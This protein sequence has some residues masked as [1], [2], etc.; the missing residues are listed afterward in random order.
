LES[1]KEGKEKQAMMRIKSE[2]VRHLVETV[3]D[4]DLMKRV[5]IEMQLDV[6]KL[7]IGK[8]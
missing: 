8:L 2:D 3:W 4:L 7:P 5:M 6:D 1:I